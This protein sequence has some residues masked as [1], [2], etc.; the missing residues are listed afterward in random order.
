MN[1]TRSIIIHLTLACHIL[2]WLYYLIVNARVMPC[3]VVMQIKVSNEYIAVQLCYNTL[4]NQYS[5]C[6]YYQIDTSCFKNILTCIDVNLVDIHEDVNSLSYNCVHAFINQSYRSDTT[7]GLTRLTIAGKE[8]N[9]NWCNYATSV[10]L[11][12]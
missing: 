1:H 6:E 11:L 9:I 10:F 5:W 7:Q 12:C 3:I 4:C 8:R 2:D